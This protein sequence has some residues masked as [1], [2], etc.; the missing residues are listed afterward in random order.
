M[1]TSLGLWAYNTSVLNVVAHYGVPY[2][3]VNFWLVL[4]T[5]LQHT[6]T[7]L[8]HYD[9]ESWTWVKGALC[10][11]DRDYGLL[12]LIFHRIGD[13]HVVHHLFHELPHY[14]AL[15]ATAHIKAVLGPFYRQ[16]STPIMKALWST[17]QT[18]VLVAPDPQSKGVFWWLNYREVR[19]YVC[20][21]IT[22]RKKAE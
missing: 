10:T 20:S 18:C 11:V 2:L 9:N 1:L 16:D 7:S 6:D 14:H 22:Q 17:F 3:W 21:K 5:L 12:N 4:I 15:E 8:P 19:S 13:T